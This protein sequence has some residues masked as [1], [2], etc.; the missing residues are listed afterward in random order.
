[1]GW[2][3]Q[4]Q[5]KRVNRRRKRLA[6]CTYGFGGTCTLRLALGGV[7]MREKEREE[8]KKKG[9]SAEGRQRAY[10]LRMFTSNKL[11][12]IWIECQPPE[13]IIL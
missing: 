2:L 12:I 3:V 6:I 9:M 11:H 4:D 5:K 13:V 1:M 10:I 8:D 7:G